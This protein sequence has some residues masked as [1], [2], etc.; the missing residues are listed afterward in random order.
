[1][2]GPEPENSMNSRKKGALWS[3]FLCMI[4]TVKESRQVDLAIL[5]LNSHAAMPF[6]AY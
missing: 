3:L 4:A 5:C 2:I 6:M 1:M